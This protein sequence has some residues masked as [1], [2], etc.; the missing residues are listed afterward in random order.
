MYFY[1]AAAVNLCCVT[2]GY[3]GI[4]TVHPARAVIDDGVTPLEALFNVEVA[5]AIP[6]MKADRANELVIRMLEK[7]EK[8]VEKAP[9]GKRFQECFDSRTNK[10]S[11]KYERLYQE[12]KTEL[13][14]MGI[15][16]Q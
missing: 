13:A 16:L 2:S 8:E 4:Q 7:Y 6:G 1:E 11:E 14:S 3:A 5:Q 10:P 9:A 12:V 15:P